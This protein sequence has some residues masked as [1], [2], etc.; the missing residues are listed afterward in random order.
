M[1]KGDTSVYG[2]V[3]NNIKGSLSPIIHNYLSDYYCINSVYT[4]F[5]VDTDIKVAIDGA[6]ALN[7]QGLNV[8]MPYKEDVMPFVEVEKTAK[9][10]GAVNTLKFTDNGY[11]GHNTDWYGIIKTITINNID[12]E[13]KDILIVGAGG[14]AFAVAYALAKLKPRKIYIQNRTKEKAVAIANLLHNLFEGEIIV[15]NNTKNTQIHG[16]INTTPVGNNDSIDMMP[17]N[18]HG[19][20]QLQFVIDIIYNP[21]KTKLLLECDKIGIK[22]IN[23]F[24]M[25]VYQAI[26]SFE[27]WN[28]IVIN[29]MEKSIHRNKLLNITNTMCL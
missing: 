3:G 18:I 10:I 17:V 14:S 26:R 2:L 6:K 29:D 20:S 5:N 9:I 4:T 11:V 19:M 13:N 24:D 28:D 15:V 21:R 12:V 22:A 23:G 7:I 8:T 1:I 27:I 16:I 25:L